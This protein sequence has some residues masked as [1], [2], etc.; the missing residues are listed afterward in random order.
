MRAIAS[1]NQRRSASTGAA[2]GWRAITS[3]WYITI[4]VGTACTENRCASFGA[5]SIST[6]QDDAVDAVEELR[7]EM[8]AQLP[9]T[10]AH[11]LIDIVVQRAAP[12]ATVVS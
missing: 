3:P 9:M 1:S 11:D 2:P 10:T 12:D 5:R 8:V 4:R 6:L 7:T